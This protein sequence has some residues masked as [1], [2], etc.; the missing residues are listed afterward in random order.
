ME[1]E[2]YE[3]FAESQPAPPAE[4]PKKNWRQAFKWREMIG[5]TKADLQNGSARIEK[6]KYPPWDNRN[7]NP[8]AGSSGSDKIGYGKYAE[9]SYEWVKENDLRYFEWCST[10]I[11]KF[12]ARVRQLGL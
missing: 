1:Y 11:P 12:G 6:L 3:N 5:I 4:P 7:G 10:N 8:Q 9:R 2:Q